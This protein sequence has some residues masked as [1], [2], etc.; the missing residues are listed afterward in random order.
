MVI[1]KREMAWRT[2][3]K[4]MTKASVYLTLAF[5]LFKS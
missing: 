4:I 5:N 2:V 1:S 3:S